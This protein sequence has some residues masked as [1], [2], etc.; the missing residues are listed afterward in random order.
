M[1]LNP[2]EVNLDRANDEVTAY[3]PEIAQQLGR[4]VSAVAT[5]QT[6]TVAAPGA[7][8]AL[9][10]AGLHAYMSDDSAVV[11]TLTLTQGGTAKTM[12]LRSADLPLVGVHLVADENTAV[13][14]GAPAGGVG[15]TSVVQVITY[16]ES[17]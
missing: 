15:V 5:A 7:G 6:V 4:G 12:T 13:T 3:G 2:P 16:M 1:S 9:H 17:L 10:F 11:F 14:V 8:R